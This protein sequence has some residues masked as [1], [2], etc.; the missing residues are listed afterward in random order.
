M[1]LKQI[2]FKMQLIQLFYPAYTLE[3][4]VKWWFLLSTL[5]TYCY[6]LQKLVTSLKFVN[7][8][9]DNYLLTLN[10]SE[11]HMLLATVNLENF[12]AEKFWLK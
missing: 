2:T 8:K 4:E 6:Y 11:A 3:K 9:R 7:T 1:I 12:V 10:Y 5:I